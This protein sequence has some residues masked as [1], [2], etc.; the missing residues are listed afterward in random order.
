MTHKIIRGIFSS[1]EHEL[2]KLFKMNRNVELAL[3]CNVPVNPDRNLRW[4]YDTRTDQDE[5]QTPDWSPY[6]EKGLSDSCQS[7]GTII[8]ISQDYK[9]TESRT[10]VTMRQRFPSSSEAFKENVRCISDN[11]FA[12]GP[13][14]TGERRKD[15]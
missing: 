1:R 8:P 7:N 2:I 10:A 14:Q 15:P 4:C 11:H 5:G 6:P 3:V 9:T 13:V 12:W